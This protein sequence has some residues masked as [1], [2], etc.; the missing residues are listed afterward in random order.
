MVQKS[1]NGGNVHAYSLN[2][3]AETKAPEILVE[4]AVFCSY[5]HFHVALPPECRIRSLLDGL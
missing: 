2:S 4:P 5:A 1:T 3:S